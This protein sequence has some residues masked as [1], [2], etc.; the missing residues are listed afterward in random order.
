[1]PF[2]RQIRCDGWLRR[3]RTPSS[4]D[5][6]FPKPILRIAFL[7]V[8]G[9]GCRSGPESAPGAYTPAQLQILA[10]D[11]AFDAG[12]LAGA[13]Q[14]YRRALHLSRDA[15]EHT[16]EH[17]TDEI[18]ALN[19]LGV[20][21]ERRGALKDAREL[22]TEALK[23]QQATSPGVD[24]LVPLLNLASVTMAEGRAGEARGYAERALEL[25]RDEEHAQGLAHRI[26]GQI[27][28]A[29]GDAARSEEHLRRSLVLLEQ[30][31]RLQEAS[32]T[33]LILGRLLIT[34]SRPRDAV[35]VLSTAHQGFRTVK[36]SQGQ[37]RSLML[38]ASAYE[39]I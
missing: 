24:E 18:L 9:Q 35:L 8:L 22:Y 39:G 12:D 10:G 33:A 25:A 6:L 2:L 19:Q 21:A 31:D 7:A 17:R 4:P 14:H 27:A 38:L 26:L 28:A 16:D 11:S 34:T 37:V 20:L 3:P 15:R 30:T 32:V 23:L 36:D 1:M 13:E 29:E 5:R